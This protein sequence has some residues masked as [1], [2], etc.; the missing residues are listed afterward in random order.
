[1]HR[2]SRRGGGTKAWSGPGKSIFSNQLLEKGGAPEAGRGE[3][4]CARGP[5][6]VAAERA[7]NRELPSATE[8]ASRV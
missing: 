4:K 6:M 5:R 3:R 7:E 8:K 2:T 1:M